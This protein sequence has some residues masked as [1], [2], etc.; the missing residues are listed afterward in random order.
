MNSFQTRV[1]NRQLSLI[2]VYFSIMLVITF[3]Q[4]EFVL[5]PELQ[6][7]DVISDEAKAVALDRYQRIRWLSFVIAP[8]LL[9]T[10]L[11]LV[12]LC[13]YIGGMFFPEMS[14]QKYKDWW[15][16]AVK[17]QSVIIFYSVILCVI[18]VIYG[19]NKAA[20]IVSSSSL[21]FIG[22]EFVENWVKFP[23]TAV[24][25]FEILY[26]IVMSALVTRLVK[27]SFWKSF[28]F[29][30]STYGIGYLCYI[31]FIMFLILYIG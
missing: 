26:W 17:A 12:S 20:D 23:L 16:V 31:I 27:K 6:N 11:S 21:L 4:Q 9:L 18:N 13:L 29:V 22:G 28:K 8:V 25:I 14:R 10:R 1:G 7:L 2:L 19:S 3:L 30:M 24:N 15:A 5:L